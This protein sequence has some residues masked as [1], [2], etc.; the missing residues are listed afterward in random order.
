MISNI[1]LFIGGAFVGVM[2]MSCLT[3]SSIEDEKQE[4]YFKGLKRGRHEGRLE[5]RGRRHHD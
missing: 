4:A 1:I 2:I 5:E 3:V